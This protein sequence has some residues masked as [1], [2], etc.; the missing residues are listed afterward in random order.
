M[1]QAQEPCVFKPR[2][3]L[4]VLLYLAVLTGPDLSTTVRWL[5]QEPGIPTAAVQKGI[6]RTFQ[7]RKSSTGY[8]IYYNGSLVDW[9]S[10]RQTMVTLSS[11]ESEYVAM[12]R[13]VQEYIGLMMVLK[14]LGIKI[15]EIVALVDNQGAQYLAEGKGVTQRSRHIDT[16]YHWL[17][18]K[19]AS[20][21]VR[22][23]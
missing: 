23:C 9:G 14:D 7:E 19:V 17:G 6:D 12:A 10:K 15:G 13:E 11:T 20:G 21:D 22:V 8:A 18:E 2:S 4:G 16:K 3:A 5:A 1:F